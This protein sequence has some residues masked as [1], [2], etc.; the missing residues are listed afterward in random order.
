MAVVDCNYISDYLTYSLLGKKGEFNAERD[1]NLC[2]YGSQVVGVINDQVVTYGKG[3]K[4]SARQLALAGNHMMKA[5]SLDANITTNA[6]LKH[7]LRQVDMV[8]VFLSTNLAT[9][10]AFLVILSS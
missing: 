4:E 8:S 10:V 6:P 2:N 5:I 9:I 3:Q 7:Q 1:Y